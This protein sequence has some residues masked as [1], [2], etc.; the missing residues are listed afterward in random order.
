MLTPHLNAR[1]GLEF[2]FPL[3]S[4]AVKG[5][6]KELEGEKSPEKEGNDGEEERRGI[7][8]TRWA[9]TWWSSGVLGVSWSAQ[10]ERWEIAYYGP[11]AWFWLGWVWWVG[12]SPK[13]HLLNFE[14][15]IGLM[16]T[17]FEEQ[18]RVFRSPWLRGEWH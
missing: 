10:R 16:G 2:L 5:K 15:R 9:L 4:G 11:M 14:G 8:H 13:C 6:E 7:L 3:S 1:L 12:G 17:S 18:G